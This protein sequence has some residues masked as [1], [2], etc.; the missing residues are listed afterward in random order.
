[1][2]L[3]AQ[4]EWRRRSTAFRRSPIYVLGVDVAKTKLDVSL[5]N[6]D[7]D[8]SRFKT[9]PN[10]PAGFA[11]LRGWL[12][13]QGVTD[14]AQ[15]HLILEATGVYHEVAALGF[16]EAGA[17]VSV[18]NPAQAKAFGQGLAVRTKTDARD[19]QVLAR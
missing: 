17:A 19:S 14:L 11:E 12:G 8:Q 4:G 2:I 3:N 16:V 6:P 9:V 1:M 5:L 18:V 7:T 10:T 15:V 13:R